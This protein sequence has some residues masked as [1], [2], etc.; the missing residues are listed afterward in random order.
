[1]PQPAVETPAAAQ[2]ARSGGSVDERPAG[3]V[4][5]AAE[6]LHVGERAADVLALVAILAVGWWWL[7]TRLRPLVAPT[8]EPAT[9]RQRT[10]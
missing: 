3:V 1:M 4:E 7:E 6:R 9:T 5:P 10:A 8:A 2:Q